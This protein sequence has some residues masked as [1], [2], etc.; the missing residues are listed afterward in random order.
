M[1]SK[2]AKLKSFH[3]KKGDMRRLRHDG[4]T[5]DPE[6]GN[7]AQG[8]NMFDDEDIASSPV[9]DAGMN[10]MSETEAEVDD[11]EDEGEGEE[12]EL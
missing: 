9:A 6:G 1:K 10:V 11:A 5:P 12:Q 2:A 3:G 7:V 4:H 8:G